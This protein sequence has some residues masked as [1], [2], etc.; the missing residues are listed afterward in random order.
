MGERRQEFQ[1]PT[2]ESDQQ[3]YK[4]RQINEN[5]C[6]LIIEDGSFQCTVV[7]LTRRTATDHSEKTRQ[8]RRSLVI[9]GCGC[10]SR[11]NHP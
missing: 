11:S 6:E 9:D 8:C 7:G 2:D 1:F 4:N 5:D 10:T 3:E